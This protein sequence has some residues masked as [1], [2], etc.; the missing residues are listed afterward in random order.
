MMFRIFNMVFLIVIFVSNTVWAAESELILDDKKL[1]L[2]WLNIFTT[3]R[4]IYGVNTANADGSET[5]NILSGGFGDMLWKSGSAIVNSPDGVVV[6]PIGKKVYWTNMNFLLGSTLGKEKGSVARANLDGTEAELI[7]DPSSGLTCPKQ[8]I[9]DQVNKKLYWGD[10]EGIK[11][12][13]SNLDGSAL[14]ILVDWSDEDDSEHQ[15]VGV[16]YN[17]QTST[18]Y[19]SDRRSGKIYFTKNFDG[20]IKKSEVEKYDVLVQGLDAPL[21]LKLDLPTNRL[22]FVERG[23]YF[24]RRC[25]TCGSVRVTSINGHFNKEET[26]LLLGGVEPIGI[27]YDQQT[28]MVYYSDFNGSIG[29]MSTDGSSHTLILEPGS[30]GMTGI[31]V[32]RVN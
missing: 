11:V 2:W 19:W 3:N 15:I 28:A 13:R 23:N 24:D 27:D 1:Q 12:W 20:K 18:L 25:N 7:V 6:D 29:K 4:D 21:D 16:E 14:E 31:D 17:H 26:K 8:I 9:L 32:V 30:E 10:R 5:K 22:F